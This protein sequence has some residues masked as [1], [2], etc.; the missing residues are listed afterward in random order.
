MSLL[1][2]LFRRDPPEPCTCE[3]W[4]TSGNSMP[5]IAPA[6]VERRRRALKN[7]TPLQR[8]QIESAMGKLNLKDREKFRKALGI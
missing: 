5:C 4:R 1:Q 3:E 7:P 2:R 6:C 8:V